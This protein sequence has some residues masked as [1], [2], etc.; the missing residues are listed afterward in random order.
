M[1]YWS[2]R[3]PQ[4]YVAL[5]CLSHEILIHSKASVLL[6]ITMSVTWDLDPLESLNL[7][8]HYNTCHM[9]SW[10]CRKPQPY[11][12]LQCLSHEI[13]IHSKASIVLRIT[14][15]VTWDLDPLESLSLTSQNNA[16]HMRSWSTWI[17]KPF[18]G[19]HW[20]WQGILILSN[21]LAFLLI[22][23]AVTR[24]I[25]PVESLSL[26]SHYNSCHMSSWSTPNM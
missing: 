10:S 24:N 4:S 7:T 22:V 15:P 20:L 11:F 9:R 18:S 13:L 14:M 25:D 1:R 23:L 17:T 6:R 16:L 12:A 5:Q 2:T 21:R 3:K 19:L 26:T 8:S